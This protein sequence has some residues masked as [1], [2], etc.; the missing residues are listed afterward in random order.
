MP[1]VGTALVCIGGSQHGQTRA[2]ENGGCLNVAVR[3]LADWSAYLPESVAGPQY[4]GYHV[5]EYVVTRAPGGD[6]LWYYLLRP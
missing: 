6:D 4:A 3:T 1:P 5:E 2:C